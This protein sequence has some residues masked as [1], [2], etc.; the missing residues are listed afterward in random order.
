M[1]MNLSPDEE[2]ALSELVRE[3]RGPRVERSPM[4]IASVEQAILA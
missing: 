4:Q 2:F 1:S 3:A